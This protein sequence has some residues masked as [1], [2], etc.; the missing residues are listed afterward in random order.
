MKSILSYLLLLMLTVSCQL[1]QKEKTED[2]VAEEPTNTS[3]ESSEADTVKATAIFWVDKAEIIK[4]KNY[5]LRTVKA[6][7]NIHEDGKVD[8]LSFVKQQTPELQ[9]YVLD[10][11]EEFQVTEKMLKGGYIKPGEQVVQLRC[12]RE[13][14]PKSK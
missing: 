13:M 4:L 9:Q 5:T 12:I 7:V 10:R 8:F 14:I 11:L 2:A 1:R 6:K 3:V